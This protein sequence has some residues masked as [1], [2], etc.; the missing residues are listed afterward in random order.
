MNSPEQVFDERATIFNEVLLALD[1]TKSVLNL[2][3]DVEKPSR[4]PIFDLLYDMIDTAAEQV[5]SL[6]KT[7]ERRANFAQ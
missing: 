3:I 4:V 5:A 7:D 1:R 2:L 6:E